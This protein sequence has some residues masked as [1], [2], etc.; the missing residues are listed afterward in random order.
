[1]GISTVCTRFLAELSGLHISISHNVQRKTK[2]YVLEEMYR[3]LYS[4]VTKSDCFVFVMFRTGGKTLATPH[5]TLQRA[6]AG[7]GTCGLSS[8][9]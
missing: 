2:H 3:D 6:A 4:T 1:M 7:S 8:G 9:S 5:L